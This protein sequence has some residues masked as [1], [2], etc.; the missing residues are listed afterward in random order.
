MMGA[1]LMDE[2]AWKPVIAERVDY[3]CSQ[4]ARW[5][6]SRPADEMELGF[7]P[8][9]K[10]WIG[11]GESQRCADHEESEAESNWH[12]CCVTMNKLIGDL[13]PSQQCAVQ[14]V[15]AG[16]SWRFPRDNLYLLL[17]EAAGNLML[18]MNKWGVL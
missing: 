11:G 14:S 8:R 9:I 16:D 6:R 4:W 1:A 3:W 5:M 10:P 7:P 18:G 13:P 12:Y 17:E 15:Y 2:T